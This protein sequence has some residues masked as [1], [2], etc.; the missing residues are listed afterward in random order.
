MMEN[1]PENIKE[2]LEK[3]NALGAIGKVVTRYLQWM[4][5]PD[6]VVLLAYPQLQTSDTAQEGGG[7]GSLE[8][9]MITNQRFLTLGA[10]PTYHHFE[11]LDIHKISHYSF[12]SRFATGY[13]GEGDVT[14]AEERGY[15]P[16]EIEMEVR[17]QDEH[18]QEIFVWHQD[19]SRGE[20]IKTLFQFVPILSRI[21]GKPLQSQRG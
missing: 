5:Q 15:N 11:V 6:E 20:D 14:T 18:G 3:L 1:L 7:F 19:A 12:N 10:Y 13:E 4:I 2:I 8:I 9:K 16:R 17:F 21:A